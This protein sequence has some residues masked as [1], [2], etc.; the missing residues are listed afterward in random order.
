MLED[1]KKKKY[2]HYLSKY[3]EIKSIVG[4]FPYKNPILEVWGVIHSIT[5]CQTF[6]LLSPHHAQNKLWAKT[7]W[8][9]IR[10]KAMAQPTI[11]QS[12]QE[13]L[14]STTSGH[15]GGGH[16]PPAPLFAP[17]C[18]G[19]NWQDVYWCL[20]HLHVSVTLRNHSKLVWTGVKAS[21]PPKKGEYSL[22]QNEVKSTLGIGLKVFCHRYKNYLQSV[23]KIILKSYTEGLHIYLTE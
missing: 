7:W 9:E 10:T 12:L 4:L 1:I 20:L 18:R 21:N 22:L 8:C 19:L 13:T 17:Q 3:A 16:M 6:I 2:I 23:F 5:A 14:P 11:A 15:T